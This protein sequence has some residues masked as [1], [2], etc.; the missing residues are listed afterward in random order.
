MSPELEMLD[1]LLDGQSM[2]LPVIAGLFEDDAYARRVLAAYISNSMVTL[3]D[4]DGNL[5]AW[6]SQEIFRKSQ[7]LSGYAKLRVA[8]TRKGARWFELGG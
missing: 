5:P 1:Q 4:D 7:P 8:I 2:P 6:K 3:S